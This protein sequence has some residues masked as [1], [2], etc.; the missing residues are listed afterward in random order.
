MYQTDC[1]GCGLSV[2]DLPDELGGREFVRES[3]FTHDDSGDLYCNGCAGA[4]WG[5]FL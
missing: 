4:G 5:V 2:H 1:N 3:F